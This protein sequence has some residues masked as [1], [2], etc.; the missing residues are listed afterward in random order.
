MSEPPHALTPHVRREASGERAREPLEAVVHDLAALGP[1]PHGS[2]AHARA[3]SLLSAALLD[4]G[5]VP[6][7]GDDVAVDHPSGRTNL[8]A[9]VPGRQRHCRPLLLATHYDGAAESPGAGDN[10]AAAA[11]L[12]VVAAL[13]AARSMERDVIV[14]LVDGGDPSARASA[15]ARATPGRTR[16]QDAGAG[17]GL[18][19]F[20]REQCRHDLKVGV[21]IDRVGHRIDAAASPELLVV[22][23]ESEARL[24]P[25]LASLHGALPTYAALERRDVGDA[26]AAD[27]L[28]AHGVPYLWFSGGRMPWHRG[29]GDTPERLHRPSLDA[30]V[31]L[32]MALT[33]RLS[34]VRLP[35]PAGEH[36][37]GELRRASWRRWSTLPDG[38]PAPAD[39]K[40]AGRRLAWR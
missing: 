3:R 40:A 20:L 11:V 6:Y 25:V 12:T 33:S 39:R 15:R 28:R 36:D 24:A 18:S 35:G 5:A 8:L 13:L 27:A 26:P 14:A 9:V 32:L 21:L 30:A 23:A 16:S 2:P 19:V 10:A 4:A 7:V 31:A 34:Q 29:P 17:H 22:G 38:E 1:R 37:V